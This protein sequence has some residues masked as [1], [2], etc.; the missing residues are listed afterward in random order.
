MLSQ[1]QKKKNHRLI[2]I[3]ILISAAVT[4][5]FVALA[6][7][8]ASSEYMDAASQYI[9]TC[10]PWFAVKGAYASALTVMTPV[11]LLLSL[12]FAY[13]LYPNTEGIAE[14]I[15]DMGGWLVKFFNIAIVI[16]LFV[17]VIPD[18]DHGRH[19]AL[20]TSIEGALFFHGFIN[21]GRALFITIVI[22]IFNRTK[23]E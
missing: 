22:R 7:A 9:S 15:D 2:V 19:K 4:L 11:S 16:M 21:P 14:V 13:I 1:Q 5:L 23:G 18:Y 12:I 3:Q 6:S 10:V 17:A 20:S 8:D